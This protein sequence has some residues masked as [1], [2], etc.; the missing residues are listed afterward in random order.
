MPPKRQAPP[1]P[2]PSGRRRSTRISLSGQKSQYFEGDDSD[3]DMDE[4]PGKRAKTTASSGRRRNGARRPVDDSGDSDADSYKE[5]EDDSEEEDGDDNDGD[6]DDDDDDND[7]GDRKRAKKGGPA[8]RYKQGDADS[9]SDS[10][11][12]PKVTFVPHKKLRDLGGVDYVDERVH[13]VTMDFLKDLK[14]N[15]RREWLKGNDAEFRRAQ[16]DWLSFVDTLGLRLASDADETIPELPA[17]DVVFRIYRDVRFS[18]DQRPYKPHFSAAWSRTGKKGPYACYYVHCEPGSCF[19]GGGLWHP[20]NDSLRLLRA[21]ID[22]RPR[23]W[24][25]VLVENDTLRKTWLRGGAGVSTGK[26]NEKAIKRAFAKSNANGALKT[27]P[28]GYS[29]D[30]RDIELLKLRNFTMHKKIPDSMFTDPDGQDQ[31]IE[32]LSALTPFV[33]L[34]N[35]IVRPDPGEDSDS[36]EGEGDEAEEDDEEEEEEGGEQEEEDEDEDELAIPDF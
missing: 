19:A 12:A 13:F 28:M 4:R 33:T 26:A 20:D 31:L 11:A 2:E 30:H 34:L 5:E 15:N 32:L 1:T 23:W 14:A 3:V 6:D 24:R 22:E 16:K 9:D 29:A 8:S 17:K 18:K 35:R 36:E 25:R 21:S 7:G 27:K 10:D